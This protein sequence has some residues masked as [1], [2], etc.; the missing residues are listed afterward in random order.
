MFDGGAGIDT[1]SYARRMTSVS[2]DLVAGS[3]G[4]GDTQSRVESAVGGHGD[5]DLVVLHAA[6][7]GDGTDLV[8]NQFLADIRLPHDCEMLALRSDGMTSI[9]PT[10]VTASAAT[11]ALSCPGC[12][13]T[14]RVREAGRR[15]RRL[16]SGTLT[17]GADA[18]TV[19]LTPLGRRLAAR[20]RGV[21]AT[22]RLAGYY[23]DGAQPKWSFKLKV[24]R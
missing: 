15:H 14:V 8:D 3:S 11:F 4:E 21:W 1:V 18:V 13:P 20:A 12:T 9:H 16:A 7:C 19:T 5:D 24:P 22:V 23:A 6:R 2:V 17:S 10:A